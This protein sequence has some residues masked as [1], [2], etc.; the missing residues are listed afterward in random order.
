[1]ASPSKAEKIIAF[2]IKKARK[3]LKRAI[4]RW[5]EICRGPLSPAIF[6]E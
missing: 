2:G 3:G 6:T 1:M 5:A 4:G